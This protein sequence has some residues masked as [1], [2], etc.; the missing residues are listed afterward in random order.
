MQNRISLLTPMSVLTNNKPAVLVCLISFVIG[1]MMV[2]VYRYTSDQHAI[3]VAKDRL[4]AHLLALRLF[5]DQVPVVLSS[6]GRILLA[7]GS[8]LR[9][10]FKPLAFVIIP[11]T[12]LIV[13]VDRYLGSTPIESGQAF[14]LK[15]RVESSDML[16]QLSLQL[17]EGLTSNAPAVHV[18]ADNEIVWRVVAAKPGDYLVNVEAGGQS[19]SKTVAIGSGMPRL[20]PVRFRGRMWERI[21]LSAEPALPDNSAIAAIE[22]QYPSRDIAFAGLAWNWIWLFFVLSLAVGF[23]AKSILGIEI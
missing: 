2:V 6:Y 13:Q 9:L 22:V 14:L 17:P 1:L 3:H 18:A 5:Q 16:Q 23:L 7:T 10:T 20:S 21:F 4:K 11:L 12:F 19:L 8:Y 15:A